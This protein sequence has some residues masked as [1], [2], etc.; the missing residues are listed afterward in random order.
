MEIDF[1]SFTCERSQKL[2][3]KCAHVRIWD[4]S[5]CTLLQLETRCTRLTWTTTTQL[6]CSYFEYLQSN[7][8][9]VQRKHTWM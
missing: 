1:Q 7:Q 2:N 8:Q 4:Q 6:R 3:L 9:N 5:A